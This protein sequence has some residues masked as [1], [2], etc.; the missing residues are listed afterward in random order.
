MQK[1]HLLKQRLIGWDI[2]SLKQGFGPL[3][4]K[5]QAVLAI[6][7]PS[8]FKRLKAFLGS[9]QYISKFLSNLHFYHLLISLMTGS[10]ILVWIKTQTKY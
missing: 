7:P 8:T 5:T 9:V 3:D 6:L 1:C 10:E 2:N 4:T